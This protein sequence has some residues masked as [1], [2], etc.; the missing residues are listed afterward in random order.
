[1]LNCKLNELPYRAYPGG[2]SVSRS[3]GDIVAKDSQFGGNPNVIIAKP[4]LFVYKITDKTDFIFM[5]CE[6]IR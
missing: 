6:L 3:F 5:G 1:M 4:D 2:L